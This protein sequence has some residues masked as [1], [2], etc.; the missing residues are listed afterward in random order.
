[1]PLALRDVTVSNNSR[2]EFL[3]ISPG[4]SQLELELAKSSPLKAG[5]M[6]PFHRIRAFRIYNATFSRYFVHS[7]AQHAISPGKLCL[8][9]LPARIF[10][11]KRVFSPE[12]SNFSR[13]K[14]RRFGGSDFDRNWARPFPPRVSKHFPNRAKK[15]MFQKGSLVDIQPEKGLIFPELGP[16]RHETCRNVVYFSIIFGNLWHPRSPKLGKNDIF[17][18][19]LSD[20]ARNP[21]KRSVSGAGRPRQQKQNFFLL[22]LPVILEKILQIFLETLPFLRTVH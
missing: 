13:K 21:Y 15:K 17:S 20:V 5:N 18:L 3:R 8:Q 2:S 1:M 9:E 11:E 6:L 16:S 4:V 7:R 12:I 22:V 14:I 19:F 10:L